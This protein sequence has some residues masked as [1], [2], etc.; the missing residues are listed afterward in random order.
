VTDAMRNNALCG[1]MGAILVM[2]VS[3]AAGQT[4]SPPSTNATSE[5]HSAGAA[6]SG[7]ERFTQKAEADMREWGIRFHAA[8]D[9]ALRR[10]GAASAGAE[11][12][13]HVAWTQAQG[14]AS[15]LRIATSGGWHEA[16]AF[17]ARKAQDLHNA[18]RRL[19]S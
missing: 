1:L 8:G 6:P 12:D 2:G 7:R 5:K 3:Q 9:D 4:T 18:W 17:Y 14:A 13:L 11:K 10:G 16:K 19:H 15:G